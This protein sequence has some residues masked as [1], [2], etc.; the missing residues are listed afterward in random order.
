MRCALLAVFVAVFGL[1]AGCTGVSEQTDPTQV[2]Q[3][4]Q[5]EIQKRIQESMKN[6]G[7]KQ[8]QQYKPPAAPAAPSK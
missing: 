1:A 2:K 8:Q 5:E 7:G 3:V 6:Y 4:P